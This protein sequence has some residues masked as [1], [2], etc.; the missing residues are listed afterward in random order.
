ME[1][2]LEARLAAN[3]VVALGVAT[4][5]ER[6][7]LR[8][9]PPRPGRAMPGALAPDQ[10]AELSV[11]GATAGPAAALIAACAESLGKIAP[12]DPATYGISRRDRLAP[13]AN[14]PLREQVDRLSRVMGLECELYQHPKSAPLVT[15]GLAEPL[16][17]IVSARLATLPEAQQVFLLSRTL[18]AVALNLHPVILFSIPD[19]KRLLVAGTRVILPEFGGDDPHV[20]DLARRIK[21]AISRRARKALE[22][23]AP[24]YAAAPVT[25]VQGWQQA[26]VRS[27]SRAAAL[28]GDDVAAALAA[29]SLTED[30][31]GPAHRSRRA[32]IC[33]GS[34]CPTRRLVFPSRR[35]TSR[36]STVDSRQPGVHSRGRRRSGGMLRRR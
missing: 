26:V 14:H 30:P 20:E 12:T 19:L 5:E 27:L 10:A 6:D 36:Q 17:L 13:G 31:G 21:K 4:A 35:G 1:R 33:C 9:S 22:S 3:A 24:A 25:S 8:L 34:G 28:L 11:D 7:A 16:Y 2:P 29:L 18:L 23:A 15:V 32:P